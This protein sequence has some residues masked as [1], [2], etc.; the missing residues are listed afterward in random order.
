MVPI[1]SPPKPWVLSRLN[2]D[3]NATK[4]DNSVD[5]VEVVD[6]VPA[7]AGEEFT[8]RLNFSSEASGW[9]PFGENRPVSLIAS[10]VMPEVADLKITNVE[11]VAPNGI[12]SLGWQSNPGEIYRIETSTDLITWARAMDENADD[13]PDQYPQGTFSTKEVL[14]EVSNETRRFWRVRAVHPWESAP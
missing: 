3:G 14:S 7:A 11:K 1:T 9:S 13:L 10:G 8:V 6:F 12:Y 2:P 5:N 4:G